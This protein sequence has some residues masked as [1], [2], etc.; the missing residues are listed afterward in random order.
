MENVLD[1]TLSRHGIRLLQG[2]SGTSALDLRS[3]STGSFR[4]GLILTNRR[5]IHISRGSSRSAVAAALEDVPSMAI[6][7]KPME[8]GVIFFGILITLMGA[9]AVAF[10]GQLASFADV[11]N[12]DLGF[13]IGGPVALFGAI[14]AVWG[15][16]T[17][18]TE[19]EVQLGNREIYADLKDSALEDAEDFMADF[20]EAK[21]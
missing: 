19:I 3:G 10:W 21:S 20:F 2:E 7:H 12:D 17:G 15:L 9:L 16:T 6:N 13:F 4:E 8:S 11:P 1:D 5:V 18:S 14:I